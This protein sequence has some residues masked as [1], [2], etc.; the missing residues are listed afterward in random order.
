MKEIFKMNTR[1]LLE[2][3]NS[4]DDDSGILIKES[5][6]KHIIEKQVNDALKK[7]LPTCTINNEILCTC[8]TQNCANCED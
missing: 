5:T 2:I 6:L 3:V 4:V 7:Y 8:L 1:A